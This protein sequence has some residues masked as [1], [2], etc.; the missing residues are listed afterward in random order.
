M[1]SAKSVTEICKNVTIIEAIFW[2][3]KDQDSVKIDTIVK[4][5][6]S[7]GF[8]SQYRDISSDLGDDDEF[9]DDDVPLAALAQQFR[10]T[11]ED[12]EQFDQDV[13]TEDDSNEWEHN[14]VQSFKETSEGSPD[15]VSDTEADDV[16]E[17]L[18]GSELTHSE[19][20]E[21]LLKIK[22]FA[23]EKDSDYLSSVQE[24]QV[25]TERKIVKSKCLQKQYTIE[26]LFK[27]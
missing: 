17:N 8:S 11:R 20:L 10:Y 25:L 14:L 9:N 22:N 18:P 27:K 21:M 1:D 19:V 12:F 7:V 4:C 23:M 15:N 3:V 26:V 6:K 24:L 16:Q 5:F 13:P 2:V